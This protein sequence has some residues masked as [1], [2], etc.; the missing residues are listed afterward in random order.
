MRPSVAIVGSGAAGAY[1]YRACVEY[2][3]KKVEVFTDKMGTPSPGAFYFHWIPDDLAVRFEPDEI[4]YMGIGTQDKYL[5]RQWPGV[6]LEPGYASS[7]P[8]KPFVG[9]G[10]DAGLIWDELWKNAPISLVAGK[11]S[12]TDLKDMSKYHDL[13]FLTFPTQESI[14]AQGK[15]LVQIPVQLVGKQTTF[16]L[17]SKALF[18]LNK[19]N[20]FIMYNGTEVFPWVRVNHLW[21]HA[22]F[23]YSYTSIMDDEDGKVIMQQDLM[24]GTPVWKK[25]LAKNIVPVGRFARWDR[26]YLSHQSY[27][28]AKTVLVRWDEGYRDFK[29]LL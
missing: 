24:P 23:E 25:T 1:A 17:P 6:K 13:I 8:A 10:W 18:M 29:E 5:E 21:G 26:K 14:Q 11:F 3:C 2:G 19:Y 9:V 4:L 28:D 27:S 15:Y 12:D 20:N 7:F 22:S 16:Q